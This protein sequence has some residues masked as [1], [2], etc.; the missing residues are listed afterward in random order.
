MFLCAIKLNLDEVYTRCSTYKTVQHIFAAD[1]FSHK[2]CMKRYILQYAE[3]IIN[4]D[5]LDDESDIDLNE[6]FKTMISEL[7]LDTEGYAI[8]SCRDILNSKL[9]GYAISNRKVKQLLI[10]HFGEEICFTY[11]KDR[12]K[13]RMFFS[14]EICRA[15]PIETLRANNPV[16]I[17]ATKLRKECENFNFLLDNIYSNA[18]DLEYSLTQ[19][20]CG[21]YSLT[22]YFLIGK[23][24]FTCNKNVT[25]FF[26]LFSIWFTMDRKR[27]QCMLAFHR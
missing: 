15:E 8:S 22:P 7:Y 26:R 24:Q 17:C 2:N 1:I 10:N 12:T 11:P 3:E 5:E 27:L 21:K 16:K 14:T 19:Y 9:D 18:D 4:D 23:S 13:S 20:N 25:I 6:A